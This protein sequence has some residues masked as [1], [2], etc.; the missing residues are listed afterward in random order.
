MDGVPKY[1]FLWFSLFSSLLGIRGF[2]G[3]KG[4]E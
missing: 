3:S 4:L 2:L 1:V